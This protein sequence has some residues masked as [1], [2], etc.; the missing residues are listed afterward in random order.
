MKGNQ[1]QFTKLAD[2]VIL[3]KLTQ[4]KAA[5]TK[6]DRAL[7]NTVQAQFN[8]NSL[9]VLTKLFRDKDSP[10]NKIMTKF[11]EVY[12]HHKVNTI[13]YID[14]GPR[15]LP[16]TLYFEY[17]QDMKH[18]MAVVEKLIDQWM[19]FYDDLVKA[20]VMFRNTG[21]AQGRADASEYPT[22]DQ[23]RN[24]MSNDLRFQ[25]MPDVKHFLFDLS[26]EDVEAFHRAEAETL[27]LANADTINRMLKP[28]TDLT[29]RLGEFKGEKGE[30]F[31][32]SLVENVIEGC[33]IARKLVIAP[34][35]ELMDQIKELE[36]M[37]VKYLSNVEMIKA[38]PM[39]R[40][41]AQ[42]RLAEVVDKM[43]AFGF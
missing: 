1:M 27:N 34:T 4:R 8:D 35:P 20:D 18:K 30:R 6:R 26:D 32:N 28:L 25:P 21:H 36:D 38:S 14:A 39:V 15:M 3:V 9:T 40:K 11:N 16:S 33:K 7:T 29:K 43:S 41:D 42:D 13:P 19:P 5:L 12:A 24:S 37:S 23:F 10:V 17:T 31:H 22:A 2:K